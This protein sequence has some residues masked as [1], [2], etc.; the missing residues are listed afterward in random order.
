MTDRLGP[1]SETIRRDLGYF[2]SAG[3]HRRHG[4]HFLTDAGASTMGK[5]AVEIDPADFQVK[6]EVPLAKFGMTK[7]I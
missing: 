4:L 2:S 5:L 7:R 1:W 6:V 3:R